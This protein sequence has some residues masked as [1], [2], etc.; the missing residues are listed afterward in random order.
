MAFLIDLHISGG[1][2][3]SFVKADHGQKMICG[4][5]LE[6]FVLKVGLFSC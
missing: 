1:K 5:A 6:A 4:C 3:I 2:A